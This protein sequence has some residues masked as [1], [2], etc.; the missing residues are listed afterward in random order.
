MICFTLKMAAKPFQR[1]NHGGCFSTRR[2]GAGGSSLYMTHSKWSI[3]FMND[4][5]QSTS[6]IS[7]PS[8]QVV[9]M[10]FSD[11]DLTCRWSRF[12]T[13]TWDILWVRW[14]PAVPT[15]YSYIIA[16]CPL[17]YTIKI[18]RQSC[19]LLGESVSVCGP[20]DTFTILARVQ[21]VS[22]SLCIKGG[23]KHVMVC[24][25]YFRALNIKQ[26]WPLENHNLNFA[27]LWQI[28]STTRVTHGPP[29]LVLLAFF[30]AWLDWFVICNK[31]SLAT[32]LWII[33]FI[34]LTFITNFC[35]FWVHCH[36]DS[37]IACLAGS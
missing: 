8:A 29:L 32:G 21:D 31:R 7:L 16:P 15:F 18:S 3:I 22:K 1:I 33:Q 23:C 5:C 4:V 28:T 34:A 9:I 14:D 20:S 13:C 6:Y 12:I 2:V 10:T 25:E 30:V 19:V 24:H 17:I 11:N 36:I 26:K 37:L 35:G 27:H